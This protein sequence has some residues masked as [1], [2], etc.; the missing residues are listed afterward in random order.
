M[1][2]RGRNGKLGYKAFLIREGAPHLYEKVWLT[3]NTSGIPLASL[4]EKFDDDVKKRFITHF[5]NPARYMRLLEVIPGAQTAPEHITAF[6]VRRTP[7]GQG[8]GS[9]QR[10]RELHCKPDWRAWNDAHVA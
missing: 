7:V 4:V 3:S 1:G 6:N 5:F 2:G 10:H 8:C 9:G